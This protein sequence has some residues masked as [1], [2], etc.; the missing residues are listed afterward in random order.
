M[1]FADIKIG[2]KLFAGFLVVVMIFVA[3]TGYHIYTM[4]NL[5]RMQNDSAQ[6]MGQTIRIFKMMDNL[7]ILYPIISEAVVNQKPDESAKAFRGFKEIALQDLQAIPAL[8]DTPEKK[9]LAKRFQDTYADYMDLFEKQ[10]LPLLQNGDSLTDRLRKALAIKDIA[11]RVE[12]VYGLMTDLL[13]NRDVAATRQEYAKARAAAEQD[14]VAVRGLVET[15]AD[16]KASESFAAN[17]ETYLR[18]FEQKLVPTIETTTP[19]EPAPRPE[20]G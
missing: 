5:G 12:G 13:I 8:A 14:I 6:R 19:G 7:D 15:E 2:T 11:L 17:Y 1:K 16:H 20:T 18:L 4:L 10:C 3:S 9:A